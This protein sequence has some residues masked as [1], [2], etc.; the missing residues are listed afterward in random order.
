V[1]AKER[2]YRRLLRRADSSKATGGA[3]P[4]QKDKGRWS[5]IP[6]DVPSPARVYY[7]GEWFL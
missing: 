1:S 2:H 3:N 7:T 5:S 4:Q 6:S